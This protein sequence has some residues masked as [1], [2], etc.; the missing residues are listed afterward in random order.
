[1]SVMSA[2][3]PPSYTRLAVA[4]VVAAL[5]VGAAVYA[6]SLAGTTVT[7]TSIVTATAMVSSTTVCLCPTA[8][9]PCPCA[10]EGGGT[11][12]SSGI[13]TGNVTTSSLGNVTTT[14]TSSTRT[15]SA[16]TT[17]T[18]TS[19]SSDG[20]QFSPG[21]RSNG[22]ANITISVEELNLLDSVNNQTQT[23][24]WKYPSESLNPYDNCDSNGP[25]GFAIFQG[26]YGMDNYSQARSLYL[27]NTTYVSLCTMNS[28]PFVYLFAPM[29]DYISVYLGGQPYYNGTAAISFATSGYWT[30]GAGT[31]SPATFNSFPSGVYT[32]LGAD[33]WGDVVLLHFTVIGSSTGSV[34]TS[35]LT[36]C[37]SSS[38]IATTSTNDSA[39][40]NLETMPSSFTVGG[41]R[42]VMV[43]NGTGYGYNSNGTEVTNLGY[44]LVFNI[45]KGSETQTVMF[46]SA[47]PAPYPPNVPSPSTATAFDGGV[48]M[49]WVATC[50]AI[51]FEIST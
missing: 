41:Y 48:H 39:V 27:Y 32:I 28:S 6:S 20:L 36:T 47:P 17:T 15:I 5:I 29:S 35:S 24:Q 26:Y 34:T 2:Q 40:F 19:N 10:S 33:E 21:I 8:P 49:Q 7:K 25:V 30:G 38:Q 14:T 45:T 4:I 50:N 23:N 51:F 42:F 9:A 44:N 11:T 46:G 12:T 37:A 13:T 22:G 31:S 1:M 18:S 3:T 43:Y 16:S